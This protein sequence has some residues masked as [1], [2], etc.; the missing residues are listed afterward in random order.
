MTPMAMRAT[1]IEL[2]LRPK[3]ISTATTRSSG[4]GGGTL[5]PEC[6]SDQESY[7]TAAF[8]RVA[9]GRAEPIEV[10]AVLQGQGVP[11]ER[12]D[13]VELVPLE[14]GGN[15]GAL[16]ETAKTVAKLRTSGAALSLVAVP[17]LAAAGLP[18]AIAVVVLDPVADRTVVV[19][20]VAAVAA[21][22]DHL[23]ARGEPWNAL[24]TARNLRAAVNQDMVGMEAPVAAGDEVAFFPPVT[25]G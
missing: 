20:I 15:K 2:R 24:G 11:V 1:V 4:G 10:A 23:A 21:L 13:L 5:I 6:L 12:P 7:Y 14:G 17:G 9:R 16:D 8:K 22:R 18:A 25:G 19:A 3:R